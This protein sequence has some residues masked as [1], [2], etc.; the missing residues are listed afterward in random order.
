MKC[1][2]SMLKLILHGSISCMNDTNNIWLTR[3]DTYGIDSTFKV[4]GYLT[5]FIKVSSELEVV[6]TF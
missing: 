3:T 6:H 4:N 5:T 1:I 2:T